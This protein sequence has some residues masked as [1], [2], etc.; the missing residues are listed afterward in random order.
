M[1]KFKQY[2]DAQWWKGV[3][4]RELENWIKNFDTNR[5][6]AE[7]ILDNVIFYNVSQLK[8]YT[9]FLISKLKEQV[10]TEAVRQNN[11]SFVDD[12]LLFDRWNEYLD[13]TA[14]L[15]A[16]KKGDSASSAYKIIGHWRSELGRRDGAC[17]TISEIENKYNEGVR[18]FVLVDDFSG[19][20]K[21]MKE[22]L[23]EKISFKG[24]EIELGLLPDVVE[25]IQIV[26][27]VYVIHEKSRKILSGQYKKLKLIYVDLISENFNYLNER[28]LIYEKYDDEKRQEIVREIKRITK[29]IVKSNQE[30]SDL[31][32]Y[33]LN[34]P[35]V[36]EHGCPNNTLLLLFA[37]SE[38]WQQ[39][40]RRG[41][42]L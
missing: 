19:S 23:K 9:R 5:E 4:K 8:A 16:A 17:S 14:F 31:S 12:S 32:S 40:F 15:P 18:R 6:I 2:I 1:D 26:I 41:I 37:H 24:Q 36:F 22:V 27:A 35:I 28:A 34:I 7:L 42:E 20:G 25:D 21:Q 13:R 39:L 10:Y 30:L 3:E 38:N 11:F 33:V 29:T